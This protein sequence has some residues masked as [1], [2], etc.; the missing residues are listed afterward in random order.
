MTDI[1]VLA[2]NA[3]F[4]YCADQERKAMEAAKRRR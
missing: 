4:G 3:F 2:W 1:E